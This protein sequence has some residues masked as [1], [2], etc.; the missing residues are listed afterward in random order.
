MAKEPPNT[1]PETA[2]D[3]SD[4]DMQAVITRRYQQALT[5]D[6][7]LADV[8]PSLR[9]LIDGEPVEILGYEERDST[10]QHDRKYVVLHTDQGQYSSG[11]LHVVEQVRALERLGAFPVRVRV[12]AAGRSY[13]L[14]RA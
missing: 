5:V 4:P 3:W 13:K 14:V 9:S 2:S 1:L 6:D 7:V 10:I 11:S 12:V 8:T